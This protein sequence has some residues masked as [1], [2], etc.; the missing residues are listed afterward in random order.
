MH[1]TSTLPSVRHVIHNL[2]SYI[3]GGGE[4]L[5]NKP[6]PYI[7]LS[8]FSKSNI[9]F[10][11]EQIPSKSS[12]HPSMHLSIH[13]SI[14]ILPIFPT[15][16]K[17]IQIIPSYLNMMRFPIPRY[18]LLQKE[19]PVFPPKVF[20]LGLKNENINE[21]AKLLGEGKIFFVFFV[22]FFA[23]SL[24]HSV[25]LFSGF[26]GARGLGTFGSCQCCMRHVCACVLLVGDFLF[27][28]VFSFFWEEEKKN[29][30]AA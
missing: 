19:F 23:L 22:F 24:S 4:L 21:F 18:P 27:C 17:K 28:F 14:Y 15:G 2:E 1:P 20:Y 30:L 6:P 10:P 12:H 5:G 16:K 8:R 7:S 11:L 25:T 3:P 26:Q 29:A 9:L 13:P